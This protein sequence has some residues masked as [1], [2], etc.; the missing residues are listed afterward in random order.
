M[1]DSWP[2][3]GVTTDL[4]PD[5]PDR[6][7]GRLSYV[8]AVVTA[9]GVPVLLPPVASLAWRHASLC[10][11]FVLTGGDDPRT[12]PFGEPTHPMAVPVHPDRQAYEL[13]LLDALARLA[14]RKPVLGVCLG[15]QYMALHAGG[16]LNQHM[17]EDIPTHEDHRHD[18]AH[19]VR[20]VVE[21][22]PFPA[23]LVTSHHR[24]AVRDA[25]R[26][27]ALA[28]AEDGVIEAIDDP[29][30]GWYVGVQWHPERTRAPAL[31][32][33]LYDRLVGA[34]KRG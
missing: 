30:R 23:G 9:G 29:S 2:V 25:G 20:P 7:I 8:R 16:K 34:A 10:D 17:P 33:A 3:V 11:A 26:M 1:R 32:Q 18:R 19:N 6:A 5:A 28:V 4:H 24:Q 22:A 15:M 27:R 13:A 12:E 31:G 21:G 14:P